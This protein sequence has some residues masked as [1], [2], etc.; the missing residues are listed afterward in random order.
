MI[1]R[2]K[3]LEQSHVCLGTGAYQ[4]DHANRYASYV[5]NTVLG[6]SM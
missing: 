1:V 5:M 4:Q 6:G 3:E 2:N